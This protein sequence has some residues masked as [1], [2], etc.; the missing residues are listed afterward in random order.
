M[1]AFSPTF[2]YFYKTNSIVI[3]IIEN[4]AVAF[5]YLFN[6]LGWLLKLMFS[7]GKAPKIT[8]YTDSE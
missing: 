6:R 5:F 2:T 1:L 3:E 4:R 8:I 7:M